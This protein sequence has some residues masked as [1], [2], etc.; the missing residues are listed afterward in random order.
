M[1]E[2]VLRGD[3]LLRW[4]VSVVSP[5]GEGRGKL[6]GIMTTRVGACEGGV[7]W[8]QGNRGLSGST[9]DKN[10]HKAS[11]RGR[12]DGPPFL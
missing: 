12:S 10:I 7:K 3:C 1:A 9:E 4:G 5:R 11:P 8:V 6:R 2:G